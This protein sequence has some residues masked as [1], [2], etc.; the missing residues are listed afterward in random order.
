CRR[1]AGSR[2]RAAPRLDRHPCAVRARGA[3][4]AVRRLRGPATPGGLVAPGGGP[5]A[6]ECRRAA[7]AGGPPARAR[8]RWRSRRGAR[9]VAAAIRFTDVTAGSGLEGVPPLPDSLAGSLERAVALA[10][11][12]YDD[13]AT[14][15]LFVAGHLFHGDPGAGR[16]VEATA[17]AGLALRDRPVAA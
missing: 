10:V 14:E 3:R 6:G 7:R 4:Q 17:G 8:I 13:D 15:D 12:D 1:G 11:G 2:A 5:R 16:F 9:G